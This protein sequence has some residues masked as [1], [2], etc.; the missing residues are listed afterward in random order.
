MYTYFYLRAYMYKYVYL[1]LCP[2]K[3]SSCFD[4]GMVRSHELVCLKERMY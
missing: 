3:K 2:Q 1:F 4:I